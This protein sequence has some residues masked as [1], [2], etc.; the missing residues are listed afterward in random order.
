MEAFAKLVV[1]LAV[2]FGVDAALAQ[3]ALFVLAS[4]HVTA[5][6]WQAFSLV[7]LVSTVAGGASKAAS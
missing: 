2:I 1:V 3:W 5:G 4:F 7:L 6:F